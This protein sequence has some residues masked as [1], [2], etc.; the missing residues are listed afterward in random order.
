LSPRIGTAHPA[1]MRW[2][3]R[4]SLFCRSTRPKIAQCFV[5]VQGERFLHET[6][7]LS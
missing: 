4:A 2:L 7:R 6:G 3:P 1:S 5:G